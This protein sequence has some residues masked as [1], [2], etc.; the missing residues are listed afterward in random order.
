MAAQVDSDQSSS[1][2]LPGEDDGRRNREW[3]LF[4][5]LKRAWKSL[6]LDMPTLLLMMK[7]ALA[8]TICVAIYQA[9]AVASLFNTVGY[10]VAIISVLGF[11]IMPRA[12]FIQMM[13]LDVLAVC[14]ASAVA[15]LMMYSCVKAREHS[16]S[17]SAAADGSTA[18][19][20]SAAAV[21]GVWLFFEIY[22]VHTFRA[23]FQQ[24]QFPVI[25]YSIV[26]NVAFVYASR[27]GTMAAAIALVKK[28]LEACLTGLGVA[29]GVSLFILPKST[30][31]IVFKQ[32]AG[33]IGALRAAL[34][35]HTAYFETLEK[36]DMFGRAETYDST[37]EKVTDK[38]KVYSP[39][40]Q[41]I[42]TACQK[43]T[44]LHAKIHG[45][46]TFAK[47]EVAIGKLGPDDLQAI[48]RHLRQTMIPV[49]GLSFVV[50][51]FQRLSDYNKWNQPIDMTETEI[52]D[53]VRQRVRQEWNEIMR[54]V[55]DP[56]SSMIHTIDEGLHHVSLQLELT[57]P[58]KPSNAGKESEDVEA[59]AS[60][61]PGEKGF[62]E[63]YE[64]KLRNFKYA[65]RVALRTW[66]EEKGIILPPDFFEHPSSVH[67]DV[68]DIPDDKFGVGRDRSRRQ[69]YLI[70]YVEQ[71]LESTGH[72]VYD[73][74]QF[75]D[76]KVASGKLARKRLVIPGSKRL[77]KWL[78][79][80]FKAE[81]SHEDD[82]LGGDIN[83]QNN[84]LQLGEAYKH[85]KDP[86]H[87][88]PENM[89]QKIGD[90]IRLIPT[91]LRSPESAYGFRV[92][93]ATMTVAVVSFLHD[94]QDFFV[95]QRFVWAMI[96]VNLSMSPTSGQSIFGFVLRL[97]G[98]VL[99]MVL[100]LLA[101][102]IP[103][104]KTPGII[105]FFFI[106]LTCVFYVPIKIFRFRI[107]GIITI[108]ST[109]MI[110][111]YELEV[112][113]IGEQVAASNGQQYYPIYLLGPYRLATVSAGIAVA[114]IWTFFP[115]P[116]SEHS[117]LRQSLGASLYLL[118]NYYS[119]IHETVS[120]RMRGDE[121]DLALKTSSGRRLLKARNKVFSKQMLM[122]NNLRTYAGFLNWEVAIGGR[123]PKK[124]YNSIITCIEN[125]VSYLSLLGYASDTLLQLDGDD[126]SDSAWLHDFKR[127][128][129]SARVTTHEITTLLCLLSASITNRQPLPPYLKAPRPYGFSK[130]L[131][132]LDK[133]ILSLRHIA[134]PGFATFSVLQISTRCI[135][136]DVER[137]MR[138]VKALVGELDFSFHAISTAHSAKSSAEVSRLSRPPSRDKMD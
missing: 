116:I 19:N 93:C 36:D 57:K 126:E 7:G 37:V 10:L 54:A 44:D 6:E 102:Y 60:P 88:P 4:S 107:I 112:R 81:D 135:V 109:S 8:P 23:K 127:L 22:L 66:S 120:A 13:V 114:F 124:R 14:V 105:V 47:R 28:L 132:A 1:R 31:G 85:R 27:L 137:L 133:D 70:L 17:A 33:Y 5:K 87:L 55:H 71:L 72:V 62:G 136:G 61:K 18:Y 69:L 82:N 68:D 26:A 134:E 76:E 138:D 12:K 45:D 99:A 130:R 46:L 122:L 95:K 121:G 74:I 15:L 101:W 108:I 117:V 78:I 63:Y 35:A 20:S 24:F 58:P 119:V 123:F 79:S 125:I 110:V 51:I 96:M 9:D 100:S 80:A 98:T 52:P 84:I 131:E 39:E 50:D 75:A 65:K 129:A 67:L 32:M 38:G 25:I 43:V 89:L 34:N 42:R 104:Q 40:A 83:S 113:K 90:K 77:L 94:T 49:V 30:R 106:F 16:E 103:G 59:T 128:V 118:A 97:L 29:T 111:G 115:Y 41:A 56:F 64:K 3:K 86:E 91:A 21:S 92:A 73:F 2:V 11:S 53:Q 48:F